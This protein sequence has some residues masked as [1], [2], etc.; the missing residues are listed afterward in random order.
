VAVGLE[1]EEEAA[2]ELCMI[3]TGLMADGVPTVEGVRGHDT[4][5]LE[6]AEIPATGVEEGITLVNSLP[7]MVAFCVPLLCTTMTEGLLDDSPP[8]GTDA[9]PTAV[10]KLLD[11]KVARVNGALPLNAP[12]NLAPAANVTTPG[13]LREAAL[14]VTTLGWGGVG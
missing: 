12:G 13:D 7:S 14:K 2:A 3:T 11:C 10:A 1:E 4:V 9:P 8:L 6:E 5:T